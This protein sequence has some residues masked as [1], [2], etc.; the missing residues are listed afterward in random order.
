MN[1]SLDKGILSF[2]DLRVWKEGHSF[3]LGIYKTVNQF[4]KNETWGLSDQIRRASVSI[5]CNISEGYGMRTYKDKIRFYYMSQGSINEVK[6]LL[7]ISKDLKYIDK[8]TFDTLALKI[9]VIH[10]MLINLIRTTRS[11]KKNL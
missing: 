4:P 3:I 8:E 5:T 2:T 6:N 9:N 10:K 7:L 11:Y 1:S